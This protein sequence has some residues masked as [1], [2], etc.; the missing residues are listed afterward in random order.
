MAGSSLNSCHPVVF[1]AKAAAIITGTAAPDSVLGRAANTHASKEFVF[2]LSFSFIVVCFF[3][4]DWA[5]Q[6]VPT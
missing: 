2:I 1:K 3:H 6:G 5:P 4:V